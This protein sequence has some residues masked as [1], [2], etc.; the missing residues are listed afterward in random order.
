MRDC[1][2]TDDR[3]FDFVDGIDP[4]LESHV[5]SC[6]HCQEFLAELW[7]GELTTDLSQ[8]VLRQIRFDE[9]LR[10]LGQ[11]TA[12]V[13]TAFGRAIVAYGPAADQD[14]GRP[15]STDGDTATSSLQDNADDEE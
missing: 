6:D 5:E 10:E 8:P 2:T 11:L 1:R 13:A 7:I 14:A 12:D 9:F 3:L 4:D 15:G